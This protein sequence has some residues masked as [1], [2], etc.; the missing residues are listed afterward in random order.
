[1]TA[2]HCGANLGVQNMGKTSLVE[3]KL[4]KVDA[5]K[6]IAEELDC[7]LAQLS[8]AWCVSNPNVS[9]TIMGATKVRSSSSAFSSCIVLL[10]SGCCGGDFMRCLWSICCCLCVET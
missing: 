9:T 3:E 7:S 2:S 8:L 10:S 4:S 6:P 1:M 5:L